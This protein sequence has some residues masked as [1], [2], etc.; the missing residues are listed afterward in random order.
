MGLAVNSLLEITVVMSEGEAVT[1]SGY[2][3]P[4]SFSRFDQGIES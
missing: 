2:S 3:G 4:T 1:V